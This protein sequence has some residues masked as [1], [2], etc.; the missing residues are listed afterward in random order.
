M[1]RRVSASAR[2]TALRARQAADVTQLVSTRVVVSPSGSVGP[3]ARIAARTRSPCCQRV[4]IGRLARR[5]WEDVVVTT[6]TDFTEDEWSRIVRAP[7]VAG[8]A[9]SLAD[10]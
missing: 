2:P 3:V 9:I 4:D 1:S 6:K 7:F 8:M 10:P 5:R